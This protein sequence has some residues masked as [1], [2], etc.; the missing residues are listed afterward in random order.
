MNEEARACRRWR[1]LR[2][3]ERA[4]RRRSVTVWGWGVA[5]LSIALSLC[6]C[7]HPWLTVPS[8]HLANRYTA[9][10]LV[11][12]RAGRRGHSR[13][14]IEA[15]EDPLVRPELVQQKEREG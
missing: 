12:L 8:T 14:H 13:S 5:T 6:P 7:L 10:G 11:V 15:H 4:T 1:P 2:S 3:K 9:N